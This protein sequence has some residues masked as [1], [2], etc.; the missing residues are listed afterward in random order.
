MPEIQR[1]RYCPMVVKN[2]N[3]GASRSISRLAPAPGRSSTIVHS[4]P[5][6]VAKRSP[7]LTLHSPIAETVLGFFDESQPL[8]YDRNGGGAS[9]SIPRLAPMPGRL[10]TR[11]VKSIFSPQKRPFQE[12]LP[13]LLCFALEFFP[14]GCILF[15]SSTQNRP[16]VRPAYATFEVVY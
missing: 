6:L 2:R 8:L 4:R 16:R 1:V 7:R 3:G 12:N 10:V 13:F 9:R 14:L 5:V 15:H 11:V